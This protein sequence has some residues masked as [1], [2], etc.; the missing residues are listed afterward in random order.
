MTNPRPEPR[1]ERPPAKRRSEELRRRRPTEVVDAA[2][3]AFSIAA[4]LWLAWLL[5]YRTLTPSPLGI[6]YLL[7]FWVVLAYFA[8]PRLNRILAWIYVPDYFIGR[9][10]TSDGLLGDPVNLALTGRADQIH[11]AFRQAGWTPADDVTWRSSWAIVV[12][13]VLRRSYPRA[14]VSPLFLFDRQQSFAYQQ[15]VEGNPAQRHHVRFWPCPEG[16]LLPGG[17]RVDWLAAGSYDRRVGL[18]LFTLQV[19]H[20]IDADIDIERDYIVDTLHY[21]RPELPVRVIRDFSTGYHS[22][23]GGGDR[24]STD[25]NLPVID[26]SGLPGAPDDTARDAGPR[27]PAAV[28]TGVAVVA[29][30]AV[31]HLVSLAFGQVPGAL[32]FSALVST[33]PG[34]DAAGGVTL[35][36]VA[37]MLVLAVRTYTGHLGA[38]AALMAVLAA[39]VVL[40]VVAASGADFTSIDAADTLGTSLTILA[41]VALSGRTVRQWAEAVRAGRLRR[42]ARGASARP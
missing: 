28:T 22:R 37:A 20:K 4:S 15:A 40:Q 2:F 25:G 9:A 31:V 34:L 30:S 35:A 11:E 18:S 8:L 7:L 17:H 1:Y 14:P 13:S 33:P 16:W 5:L 6:G 39:R 3:F 42:A 21:A 12:S 36:A 29:V 27:R 19:T 24:I 32:A 41:L 10:R 23:N 38:R 26:V